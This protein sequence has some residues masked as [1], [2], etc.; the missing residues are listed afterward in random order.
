MEK[1]F[2]IKK[3]IKNEIGFHQE[4]FNPRLTQFWNQLTSNSG[5]VF[6]PL[7]GKSKDMVYLKNLGHRILGVEW[8]KK[9]IKEFEAEHKLCFETT[10][11]DGF[12]VFADES[13][14]FYCGDFFQ[15]PASLMK[16]IKYVYDRAAMIALPTSLRSSY[17]QWICQNLS[18]AK[19]MLLAI[20]FDNLNIGPPFSLSKNEI[21]QTFTKNFKIENILDEKLDIN[22]A[23]HKGHISYLIERVYFLIPK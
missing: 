9:A 13:Y 17:G 22:S 10:D 3:W 12:T 15:L 21:D 20:E 19:I 5:Q 2:W 7:C 1:Q 23:V 8:S 18:H 11:I 14:T 16:N 6:V 4:H